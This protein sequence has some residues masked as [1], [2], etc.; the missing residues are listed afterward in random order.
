MRVLLIGLLLVWGCG[1]SDSKSSPAPHHTK[2]FGKSYQH[3]DSDGCVLSVNFSPNG[4]KYSTIYLCE[5]SSGEM[6]AEVYSGTVKVSNSTALFQPTKVTCGSKESSDLEYS[7]SPNGNT[8]TLMLPTRVLLLDRYDG[9]DFSTL[10]A[11]M[12]ISY[13]CYDVDGYF[14]PAELKLN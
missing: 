7:L 5:L 8:L 11:S 13:G 14:T 3:I 6:G 4:K 9:P 12:D 1:K 10:N 2:M